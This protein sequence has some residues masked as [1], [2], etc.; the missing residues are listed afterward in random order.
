MEKKTEREKIVKKKNKKSVQ[1]GNIYIQSSFN[2]TIV[3]I[4]DEQGG[5][6]A[7]ATAGTLGFKGSKKSTP[8]A[9]QT[10]AASAVEK[11]RV[12]G[13]KS[14]KVFVSGVGSGRESAVRSLINSKLDINIIKD[15]TP[16]PHNGCRPK[17]IRRV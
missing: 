5:T 7:W 14:A 4:T 3:T 9:A 15:T 6:I 1:A 10:A 11:A 12:L 8:Y 2:N 13:L 16:I 17:K